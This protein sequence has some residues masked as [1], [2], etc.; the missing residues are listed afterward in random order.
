MNRF[1]TKLCEWC[2]SKAIGYEANRLIYYCSY[3]NPAHWTE[4]VNGHKE[5]A[6]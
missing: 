1:Q 4:I 6:S 2:N 3:H 5:T